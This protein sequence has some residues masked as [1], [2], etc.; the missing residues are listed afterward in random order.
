MSVGSR[1]FVHELL[2]RGLAGRPTAL[3]TVIRTRGS[4]PARVGARMIVS[5]D[6]STFGTVG[7]SEMESQVRARALELMK[8]ARS[9]VFEYDLQYKKPDSIDV[10]CGGA[11]DVLV[12]TYGASRPFP[13]AMVDEW[14]KLRESRR[15]ARVSHAVVVLGDAQPG[16]T[17]VREAG[18]G[19]REECAAE[20]VDLARPGPYVLLVGGGHVNR[21]LAALLDRLEYDHAVVD[22][23][24]GMSGAD[25][26][27]AAA[28]RFR[29]PIE[30]F[31]SE[32]AERFTHVVV[33]SYSQENDFAAVRRLLDRGYAGWLGLIGSRSK[34]RDFRDRLDERVDRVQIPVG[35]DI[36]ARS[37]PEIALSIAGSIVASQRGT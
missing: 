4:A 23:R 13:S 32:P 6:G 24:P 9:A 26:F 8:G 20:Y 37:V 31:F 21:E 5:A 25:R 14:L 35:L 2:L 34:R 30:S 1:R 10:A 19:D 36:G 27:P 16:L 17:S 22:D 12:E 15:T 11:I 18:P 7:G 3:C 29:A 33:C 28:E